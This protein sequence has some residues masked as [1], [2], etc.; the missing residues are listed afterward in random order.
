MKIILAPLYRPW[1]RQ[2]K[3]LRFMEIKAFFSS[4]ETFQF[5]KYFGNVAKHDKRNFNDSHRKKLCFTQFSIRIYWNRSLADSDLFHMFT[6]LIKSYTFHY[7]ILKSTDVWKRSF[8]NRKWT[9]A[10]FSKDYG[11]IRVGFC[12]NTGKRFYLEV[13]F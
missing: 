11:K 3:Y 7:H 4:V 10:P 9:V 1:L 8:I 6:Y 13:S 5:S 12:L 2:S